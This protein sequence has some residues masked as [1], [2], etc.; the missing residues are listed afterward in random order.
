MVGEYGPWRLRLGNLS[1]M[2][3]ECGSGS[4]HITAWILQEY[5]CTL[6]AVKTFRR[7]IVFQHSFYIFSKSY[8]SI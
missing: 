5:T 6:F 7:R 8:P 3:N 2:N 1:R 4:A